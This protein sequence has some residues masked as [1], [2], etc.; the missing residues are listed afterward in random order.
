MVWKRIPQSFDKGRYAFSGKPL[1]SGNM[2][3]L[4]PD[5]EIKE[6]IEDVRNYVKQ[7]G[8]VDYI[9]VYENKDS[10]RILCIDNISVDEIQEMKES[11]KFTEDEIEACNYWSLIFDYNYST[12]L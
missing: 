4:L 9:Q 1:L 3:L 11:G 10:D 2:Y 7:N 12:N 6:I 8:L 5:E